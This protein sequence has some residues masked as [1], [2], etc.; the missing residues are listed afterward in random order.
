MTCAPERIRQAEQRSRGYW[1]LSRLWLEVPTADRLAELHESLAADPTAALSARVLAL[2]S[3][4]AK[5]V[6][7]PDDAAAA[8]TRHLVLGDRHVREPLPYEAHVREGL[9]PGESTEQVRREICE[10]GFGDLIAEA[11]SPDHLGL[12]LRFMALLCYAESQASIAGETAKWEDCVQ[13]QRRFLQMH[14][15]RWAPGYCRALAS[16]TESG[17]LSAVARL[18]ASVV[19]DDLA[20]VEGLCG[21]PHAADDVPSAVAEVV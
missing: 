7:Q 21:A 8:F 13:R 20:V 2:R 19:R 15:A 3:E 4:V 18:T 14:L 17:Y 5:A 11:P 9:L 1:L 16:R 10:A 12:E 6:A